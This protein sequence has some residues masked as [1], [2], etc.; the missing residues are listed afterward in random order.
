MAAAI[1]L[2]VCGTANSTQKGHYGFFGII[3]KTKLSS[4]FKIRVS[5]IE[6]DCRGSISI[7]FLGVHQLFLIHQ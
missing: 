6:N 4:V 5:V 1:A 2:Y 3:E 7:T